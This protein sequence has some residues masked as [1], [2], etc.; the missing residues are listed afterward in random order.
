MSFLLCSEDKR[1]GLASKETKRKIHGEKKH[2]E[3]NAQNRTKSKKVLESEKRE[4]GLNT[5]IDKQN[6][7]FA[8]LSKM[9][10]KPGMAIGK[11]GM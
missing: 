9:G 11:S 6:K 4:E 1:P 7:G 8:L 5:A 10:Y 3:L 2:K